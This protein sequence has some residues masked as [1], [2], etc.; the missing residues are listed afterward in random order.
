MNGH[1][2]LSLGTCSDGSV[3]LVHSSPPGV[4]ICGTLLSDGSRSEAVSLAEY[5]M[6][7]FYPDWYSRYPDCSVSYSYLS[8]SSVMRWDTDILSNDYNIQNMSADE[9]VQFLY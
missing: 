2:W 6:K 5:C 7:S 1:V 8:G 3:L 9:V 4:R